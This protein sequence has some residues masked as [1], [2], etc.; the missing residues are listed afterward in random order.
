MVAPFAGDFAP[1]EVCE[2][3]DLHVLLL[4]HVLHVTKTSRSRERFHFWKVEKIACVAR[5]M[6]LQLGGFAARSSEDRATQG[7]VLSY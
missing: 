6:D 5:F 4:L 7:F 1:Y 2:T 3:P